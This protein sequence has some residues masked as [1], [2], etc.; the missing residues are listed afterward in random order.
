MYLFTLYIAFWYWLG[1]DTESE[2]FIFNNF[3]FCHSY[4]E[5]KIGITIDNKLTF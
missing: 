1:K 4:E 2:T 5:K 3:N